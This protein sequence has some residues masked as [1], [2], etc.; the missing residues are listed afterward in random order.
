MIKDQKNKNSTART[1]QTGLITEYSKTKLEKEIK[2]LEEEQRQ[3]SRTFKKEIH[4]LDNQLKQMTY[5]LQILS[6]KLKE[7]DQE[8]KL[9]EMKVKELKKQV[10]NTR[11]KPL[12]TR[13]GRTN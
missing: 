13:N 8:V 11:L 7:K 12:S 2:D 1:N 10:P 9:N 3:S 4:Q 6:I 5:E